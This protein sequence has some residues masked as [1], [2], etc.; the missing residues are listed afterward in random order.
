MFTDE[1]ILNAKCLSAKERKW[2]NEH[3]E[4][5]DFGYT[6]PVDIDDTTEHEITEEDLNDLM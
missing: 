6:G 2:M 1:K 4:N 5:K 3:P